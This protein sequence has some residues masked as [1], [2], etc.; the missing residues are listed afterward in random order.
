MSFAA[1]RLPRALLLLATLLIVT[2]SIAGAVR[3]YTPVPFWDM[4]GPYIRAF[5]LLESEGV[6]SLFSLHNE[7]RILF[8]R[9]FFLADLGLF[10]GK[11]IFLI[12]LN[13]L[14][15]ALAAL[16]FLLIAR[17][18]LPEESQ[19]SLRLAVSCLIVS[20]CFCW[21]QQENLTWGFQSQFFLAQLLPLVAMYLLYL[22]SQN[23]ERSAGYFVL[24]CVV[25]VSSAGTMAN[26]VLALPI[27]TLLSMMLRTSRWRSAV[28]ALLAI[29][30]AVLY[31]HGF[32]SANSDDSKA[33]SHPLKLVQYVLIYL[34]GPAYYMT[35]RDDLAALVGTF[36]VASCAYFAVQALTRRRNDGL[37][38]LLLAY[39]LYIG[40]SA[41][42]TA[43]GRL[44]F[45]LGQA[46]SGRYS[47]P[48]LMA[49][50]ALL[51]VYAHHFR[52]FRQPS[53]TPV[54]L[55]L[56][57]ILAMLPLQWGALTNKRGD[58]HE[59]LVAALAGEMH[60][61]DKQRILVIYPFIED[62]LR[63]SV[64][65]SKQHYSIFGDSRI[66][67]ARAEL[68]EAAPAALL[69]APA[70]RGAIDSISPIDGAP[71]FLLV[72]GWIYNDQTGTSPSTL[73]VVDNRGQI[74][75][76]A[77]SGKP[78]SDVRQVLG[79]KAR[80]S[81]FTGYISQRAERG[82]IRIASEGT[83]GCQLDGQLQDNAFS[84]RPSSFSATGRF[85][86]TL[87]IGE[88]EGWSGSDAQK[89][90]VPGY[91]V[92]GTYGESIGDAPNQLTLTLAKG[93]SLYYRSDSKGGARIALVGHEAQFKSQLPT[94]PDWVILDFD[95]PWLPPSFKVVIS[96]AEQGQA[97]WSAV[98]L[99]QAGELST[100]KSSSATH[101]ALQ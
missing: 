80:Y 34:G 29:V 39:L 68:G 3:S 91:A 26:G 37:L 12:A 65:L 21:A 48:A 36:I 27:M 74:I 64:S 93:D 6:S 47:T 76:R 20:L 67:D 100:N 28:L 23:S 24:A 2:L 14:L 88:R 53:A 59:Q 42:G 96:G 58:I 25:G 30:V 35:G 9:L 32:H 81:G 17:R 33:L 19:R 62:Y 44:T 79:R 51:I 82:P 15:A 72:Q 70:C 13:Y 40:G 49:W 38:L 75:G 66:R 43:S 45:G 22:S 7:H 98:A 4:W 85:A 55:A 1:T 90:A 92:I 78:R 101:A 54:S 77:L 5:Q 57:F 84:V 52:A 11:L 89:S 61:K 95:H 60:V 16:T 69:G 46:L 83:D 73:R 87:A 99:Q 8:A 10:G 63:S 97:G 71:D 31:F 56:V 50:A 18:C 94:A 41:L 86:S